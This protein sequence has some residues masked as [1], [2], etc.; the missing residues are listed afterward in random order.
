[1]LFAGVDL[2]FSDAYSHQNGDLAATTGTP[3]TWRPSWRILELPC[4]YLGV[5]TTHT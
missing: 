1:L 5:T 3:V 4:N 2:D